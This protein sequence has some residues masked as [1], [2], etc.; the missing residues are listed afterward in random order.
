MT[1][2][3]GGSL[4]LCAIAWLCLSLHL[5]IATTGFCMLIVIVLLS[6]LDSFI[7]SAIFSIVGGLLLNVYFTPPLFSFAIEKPQDILPI[8]AF[9]I[10]SIAIT[11]LV[12]RIRTAERLQREQARLLDLTHDT[13]FVRDRQ[14]V[15]TYWN[16]AAE[17]LYGWSKN[18]AVGKV[19]DDLLKTV[20]LVS[21]EEIQ[22]VLAR[23]GYWEGDL[24]HTRRDGSAVIV[25]SRW[26]LQHDSR[27][28]PCATLETNND[29]TQRRRAEE[30][31]RKSQAQYLAEAQQLSHTGSFG[32]NVVTGEL[33]W[34]EEAFRIFECDP[35][36]APTLETVR[37][38]LHPGDLDIF[39]RM[40]SQVSS[41][42]D[43]FDIEH[44]LLFPDGRVKHL[45][46]VAHASDAVGG[47][48]H[49]IGAVMD[50]TSARK[51]ET[52]LRQTQSELARASRISALG[53]LSASIAHEVGQ[54][55]AAIVTSGEACLRWLHRKPPNMEEVE[56]CVSEM[57]SEGTRAAEI[58]QRVRRLM[59]GAPPE[60]APV[61]V[62]ELVDEV[63][64]LTKG[65]MESHGCCLELHLAPAVPAVSGDRVQLQQ[66]LINIIINGLQSMA[67]TP[68]KHRLTVSS[69]TNADGDIV[70][71]VRDS[72][73]GI[74]EDNLTRL[75]DAFFTTRSTG[76]GMGL[77]ICTS[78]VE[79]HGGEISASNNPEGGATFRVTLPSAQ[80][81][82]AAK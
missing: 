19:V 66:V 67:T 12:R 62:N 16:H 8:A 1:L 14:N 5:R 36:R 60:H 2:W 57:T 32:W 72:G 35:A 51:T 47:S 64:A 49:F 70:L 29:I 41:T 65:E 71:S 40:L 52:Q 17:V 76:M 58:V 82:I 27:G 26:T 18:E 30:L 20:F 44:R 10:T 11:S 81:A 55:L 78:I 68:G 45:H 43:D 56:S 38:R 69:S 59:K 15:I 33:F 3:I 28:Q 24:V 53:E 39:E 23:D 9:F 50:V 77:A 25:A 54:P 74:S 80:T 22:R 63:V 46:V 21:R 48:R 34:S 13:V 75:F 6:L 7:S 42:A 37:E 31:V 73:P 79:A 4:V 61:E